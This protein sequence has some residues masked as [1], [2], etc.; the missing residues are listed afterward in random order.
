[1]QPVKLAGLHLCRKQMSSTHSCRA[2]QVH[3]NS[4]YPVDAKPDKVPKGKTLGSRKLHRMF[5]RSPTPM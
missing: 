2:L 1:M 4:L 3:F 5:H